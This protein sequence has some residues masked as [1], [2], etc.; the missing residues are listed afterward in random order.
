M[1][2]GLKSG[3]A[4]T[5]RVDFSTMQAMRYRTIP[6]VLA[7]ILL[8]TGNAAA[9]AAPLPAFRG[10]NLIVSVE[11]ITLPGLGIID[12]ITF[13]GPYRATNK[14]QPDRNNFGPRIGFAYTPMR[15]SVTADRAGEAQASATQCVRIL[16][17][18][19][20]AD[21]EAAIS[22]WD[23]GGVTLNY[24]NVATSALTVPYLVI[25]QAVVGGSTQWFQYDWPHQRLARL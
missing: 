25:G 6:L 20:A 9:G 24:T 18:T 7:L 14:V 5:L 23:S 19:G 15:G 1:R 3:S 10:G 17:I 16:D 13:D 22:S 11:H 8:V 12:P 2:E 21:A 4:L